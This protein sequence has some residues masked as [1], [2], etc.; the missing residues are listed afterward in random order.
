MNP[1]TGKLCNTPFRRITDLKRHESSIHDKKEVIYCPTCNKKFAR[2]D[3]FK[4]HTTRAHT[5]KLNEEGGTKKE[6][7]HDP[8]NQH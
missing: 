2:K 6:Y 5:G 7:A 4:R 3:G 1:I 8:G